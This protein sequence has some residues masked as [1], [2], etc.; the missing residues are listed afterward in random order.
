MNK[1]FLKSLIYFYLIIKL[2]TI[3]ALLKPKFCFFKQFALKRLFWG[4]CF[5]SADGFWFHVVP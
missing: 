5:L 1:L 3:T 4:F 2:T